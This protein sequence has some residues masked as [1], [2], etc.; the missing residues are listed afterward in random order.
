MP[1]GLAQA[2]L[3]EYQGAIE[4]LLADQERLGGAIEAARGSGLVLPARPDGLVLPLDR[5]RAQCATVSTALRA[6]LTNVAVVGMGTGGGFH[7]FDYGFGVLAG[8]GNHGERHIFAPGNGEP[9]NT[10]EDLRRDFRQVWREEIE[11][12]VSLAQD[13]ENTPEPA[14]G[15]T[16]LDNTVL[17]YV[18]DNGAEH[19]ATAREFPLLMIGGGNLGLRTGGRTVVYPDVYDGGDGHRELTNLWLTLGGPLAGTTLGGF[20]NA[21]LN[22]EGPLAEL[23]S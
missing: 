15:G 1:P 19:H 14:G 2:Q 13:L 8:K 11:G 20:G 22:A 6:G 23:M 12:L 21:T 7:G 5:L 3:A 10:R 18:A 4:D 9:E 17:V 16:M